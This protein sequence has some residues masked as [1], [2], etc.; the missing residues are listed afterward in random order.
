MNAKKRIKS[1][2]AGS[3]NEQIAENYM[4]GKRIY[5]CQIS[6]INCHSIRTKWKPIKT[7]PQYG[8]IKWHSSIVI[9]QPGIINCQSSIIAC[10]FG[11]IKWHSSIV[12]PQYGIINCQSSIIACK[13]G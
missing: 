5:N 1:F 9:P 10:K 3:K 2:L 13:Y 4:T 6:S 12:I 8:I 11:I 7:I